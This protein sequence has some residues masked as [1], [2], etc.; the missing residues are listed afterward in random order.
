MATATQTDKH[1][2]SGTLTNGTD[3]TAGSQGNDGWAGLNL[4]CYWNIKDGRHSTTTKESE[5]RRIYVNNQV[6]AETLYASSN[7][8]QVATLVAKVYK[9]FTSL[10]QEDPGFFGLNIVVRSGKDW[11]RNDDEIVFVPAATLSVPGLE[12]KTPACYALRTYA[13]YDAGWYNGTGG[14]KTYT[15]NQNTYGNI[16]IYYNITGSYGYELTKYTY[17]N[18]TFNVYAGPEGEFLS[19]VC[20]GPEIEIIQ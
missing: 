9:Q 20:R 14:T 17:N 7:G 3:G 13:G 4:T 18:V 16:S 5:G 1:T 11:E 10:D 8:Q 15:N 6:E 19:A 2:I 12:L